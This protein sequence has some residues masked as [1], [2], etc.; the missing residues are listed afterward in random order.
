M[1]LD[2]GI[3][4]NGGVFVDTLLAGHPDALTTF[5]KF[6]AMIATD[7]VVALQIALGEREE[8]MGATIF[9]GRKGTRDLAVKHDGLAAYGTR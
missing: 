8:A 9:E 2:D 6:E 5:I 7:E 1:P 4:T 3:D